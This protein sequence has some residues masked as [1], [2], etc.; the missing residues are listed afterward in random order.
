MLE[1]WQGVVCMVVAV[2]IRTLASNRHACIVPEHDNFSLTHCL[3]CANTDL[4][5]FAEGQDQLHMVWVSCLRS[6]CDLASSP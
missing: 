1:T 2:Q 6:L 3:Q 4:D 5:S